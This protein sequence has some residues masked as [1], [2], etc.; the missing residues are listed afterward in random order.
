MDLITCE[1][2]MDSLNQAKIVY[3]KGLTGTL[4][5]GERQQRIFTALPEYY[6]LTDF[7][8]HIISST[9]VMEDIQTIKSLIPELIKAQA[10][11]PEILFEVMT[12]KSLTDIKYKV[13]KAIKAQKEEND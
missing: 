4:L 13:Q 1:I 12:A 3:K 2:L 11:P 7:D 8:I 9:E 5:L 10:L 6:T